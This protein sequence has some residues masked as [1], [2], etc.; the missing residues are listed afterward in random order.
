MERLL[1][2]RLKDRARIG[3]LS[4]ERADIIPAGAAVVARL[5]RRAGAEEI[6]VSGQGLREGL[7]FEEWL[8]R[9]ARG[10]A[11]R[12]PVAPAS[13]GLPADIK[14]IARVADARA[15][16][17][18]NAACRHRVDWAHAAQVMRLALALFDALRR[19]HGFGAR[20]REWL[21]AAA[22]LHDIG[23]EVDYYRH[24]RHSAYLI[25]NADLPGFDHV[26]VAI[27]A[28]LARW[29]R[30]G[31]PRP[32]GYARMLDAADSE[33][34]RKLSAILRLAEDLERSRAQVVAA[35]RC[36]VSAESVTIEAL[37]R[38]RGEAELW[39][40]NRNAEA[41]QAIFKRA[42]HVSGARTTR[43]PAPPPPGDTILEKAHWWR[44]MVD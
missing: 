24:H 43:R 8:L 27:I 41:F 3:G 5:A 40:A 25:E 15:L 4:S 42:L 7:F 36:S 11:A 33:R 22:L 37:T 17:L 38:G 35:V 14:R 23:V 19:L 2:T 9:R 29:H 39:A 31:N 16:G 13:L 12:L 28:L 44:Q 26:E 34:V 6:L 32:E 21:A 1:D 30:Q 10:Q 18:V 20:E